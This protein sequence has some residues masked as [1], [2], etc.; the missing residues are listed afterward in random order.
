MSASCKD[1]SGLFLF[2]E[3]L[4]PWWVRAPLRASRRFLKPWRAQKIKCAILLQRSDPAGSFCEETTTAAAATEH[5]T[6][7]GRPLSSPGAAELDTLLR[8]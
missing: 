1:Y 3:Y 2:P 7:A 8:S 6:G 4:H 5:M